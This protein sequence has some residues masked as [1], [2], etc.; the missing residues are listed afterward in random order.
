MV[1]ELQ[2]NKFNVNVVNKKC[3]NSIK[4]SPEFI[5]S[6]AIYDMPYVVKVTAV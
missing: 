4:V 2:M 1:S 6:G 5:P 3:F